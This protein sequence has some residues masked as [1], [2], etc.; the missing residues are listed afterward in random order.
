MALSEK[1]LATGSL[2]GVDFKILK[3]LSQDSKMAFAELA[4][5]VNLTAPAIHARVKKLERLGVIKKYRVEIDYEKIGLPVTA[6]IRIQIGKLS[7]RDAGKKL[8][9]FDEVE[10]CHAVAGEDDLVLK[11]RTATPLELQ[12]LLDK[13]KT[14]GLVEK[15]ISVFVLETHFERPRAC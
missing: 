2:D 15:S 6:F 9:E 4:K 1:P 10:E 7:C 13:M 3:L 8:M 14:K 5:R 12:N 11:T